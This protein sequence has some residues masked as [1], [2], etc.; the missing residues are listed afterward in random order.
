MS[1][2]SLK[3][4]KERQKYQKNVKNCQREK[5]VKIVLKELPKRRKKNVKKT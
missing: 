4:W 3:K 2:K 1:K 5:N